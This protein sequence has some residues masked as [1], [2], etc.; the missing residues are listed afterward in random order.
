[1]V[2]KGVCFIIFLVSS[3]SV[4][5]QTKTLHAAKSDS[6]IK[7]NGELDDV[8]WKS[9]PSAT[10]FIENFPEFGKPC[11]QKT[12]VKII[13]TNEAVYVGAYL[14]DDPALIKKQLTQRD[15]ERFKDVDYFS[16][17]FDTY[18]DKQNAFQF[19]VTP[20]NVQSDIR[21]SSAV[22]NSNNNNNAPDGFIIT[23]MQFGIA[24]FLLLMTAG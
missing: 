7:L 20:V 17:S 3:F 14:Y 10:E 15:N 21:I 6:E 5:A 2:A 22:N 18:K 8:A 9:A 13:Y 19:T 11:P 23:G 16:V 1:M 24:G 4:F 12:E